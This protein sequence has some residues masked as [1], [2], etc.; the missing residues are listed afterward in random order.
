M[1]I[2]TNPSLFKQLLQYVINY[3]NVWPFFVNVR[4]NFTC[5]DICLNTFAC[6]LHAL[7]LWIDC[8]L[9][10]KHQHDVWLPVW[11]CPRASNNLI[12]VSASLTI[13]LCRMVAT[14][15]SFDNG[16]TGIYVS[17]LAKT[18]NRVEKYAHRYVYGHIN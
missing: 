16:F 10:S 4:T 11:S 12:A 3:T 1:L 6:I 13:L 17:K 5:A 7:P 15:C 9:L 2:C 18:K 8:I 14:N